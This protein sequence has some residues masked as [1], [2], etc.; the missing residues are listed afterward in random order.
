M[1]IV[2]AQIH[3]FDVDNEQYPWDKGP[4]FEPRKHSTTPY[5]YDRAVDAMDEAGVAAAVLVIPGTYGD[6][7]GYLLEAAERHPGRFAVVGR[8]DAGLPDLP[9]RLRDW[10]RHPAIVGTRVVVRSKAAVARWEDGGFL[11]LFDAAQ[12]IQ[13]PICVNAPGRAREIAGIAQ[14]FPELPLLIDHLGVPGPPTTPLGPDTLAPLD[15]VLTLAA[16]PNVAVKATAAS[17]LSQEAYPFHDLWDAIRR[18]LAEF[19]PERLMWGSDVT[20]LFRPYVED[21]GFIAELP[22]LTDQDK[23]LIYGQNVRRIFGWPVT[24]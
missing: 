9:A 2:D 24:S 6:E 11:P 18:V 12:Q 7:N 21:L 22:E 23:A 16:F 14:K 4:E 3:T 20:R 1:H 10:A 5:T 15:D 19:G 13:L 8:I 17:N